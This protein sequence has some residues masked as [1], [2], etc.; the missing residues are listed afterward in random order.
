VTAAFPR[1]GYWHELLAV[2]TG[3]CLGAAVLMWPVLAA[4]HH[5]V[6]GLPSDPLGEVWRLAQFRSGEIDL[7]ADTTTRMANAPSGVVL[8]R[9]IDITQSIYDVA[10]WTLAQLMEPILAYNLLVFLG[11]ATTG[12][13]TY[14]AVRALGGRPLGAATAGAILMLAPV[15]MVEAQLHAPL[16]FAAPL[17]LLL[18]LGI[19]T[20]DRPSA[21]LGAGV[22]AG[23][24]ACGY[25]TAYLL[26]EA[27][28][29]GLGIAAAAIVRAVRTRDL[30]RRLA[31][32][33]L[34]AAVAA[35]IVLAP[36]L[37]TLLAFKGEIDAAVGRA[38]LEANT[39]SLEPRAYVLRGSGTYAGLVAIA[40]A[41]VALFLSSVS[42]LV[43]VAALCVALAGVALSLRGDLAVAGVDLPMPSELVHAVV[44][45]WRVFGRVAIVASL[46]IA[47]LAALT[48]DRLAQKR[49]VGLALAL[50]LA[51]IATADLVRRPP[52]AAADLGRADPVAVELGKRGGAVAEYPLF[53]FDNHMIGPYLF[54]QLRHGR[55]LLNGAI[56]G[57][58]SADLSTAAGD[59]RGPQARA[60][61]ALGGVREL[62]VNS[63]TPKPIDPGFALAG[64]FGDRAVY[65]VGR[66]PGEVAVAALRGAYPP[67]PGPDGSNYNWLGSS[68]QLAVGRN[69]AGVGGYRANESP[70]VHR[71]H[72]GRPDDCG[73]QH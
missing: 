42:R 53:G 30:R 60:A 43:R 71:C 35:F 31:V 73:S 70:V 14:V 48:I 27:V 65:G 22:G 61:L 64:R 19:R 59:L 15:H 56:P 38:G 12:L 9:S 13:A 3:Y 37:V 32:A 67:E 29:L 8:R 1:R 57:T 49:R 28:A 51:V 39:Y 5:R 4:P 68:A 33:A 41:A 11:L 62:I 52:S 50:G 23:L 72:C 34:A 6:Y 55:P 36:L 45:Y 10:A 69:R 24:A 58:K 18:L 16:S 17:P 66:Q 63:G 25:F 54:R 20:L 2:A 47:V 44:P 21:R 26:L 40:L 7:I 46:G